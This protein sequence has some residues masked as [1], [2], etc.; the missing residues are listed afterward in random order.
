MGYTGSNIFLAMRQMWMRLQ[1]WD[2][3][4]SVTIAMQH[5]SGQINEWLITLKR[6]PVWLIKLGKYICFRLIYI[7]NE[8][9]KIGNLGNIS[10]NV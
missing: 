1:Q 2:T 6:I 7:S 3:C 10:S 9:L 4:L 5:I 8:I